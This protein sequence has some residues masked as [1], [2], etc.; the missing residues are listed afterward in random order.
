MSLEKA[1]TLAL[2]DE[3]R[4]RRNMASTALKSKLRQSGFD[5]TGY[6]HSCAQDQEC[7]LTITGTGK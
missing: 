7:G 4:N 6:T 5:E 2:T 3:Q 1:L